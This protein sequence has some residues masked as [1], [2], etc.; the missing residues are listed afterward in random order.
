MEEFPSHFPRSD[1]HAIVGRLRAQLTAMGTDPA[2]MMGAATGLATSSAGAAG[3]VVG[4]A[5][6]ARPYPCLY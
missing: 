4:G 5:A 6:P 3:S 1:K 2:E